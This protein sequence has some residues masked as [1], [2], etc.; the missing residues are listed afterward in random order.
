MQQNFEQFV[1]KQKNVELKYVGNFLAK[2]VLVESENKFSLDE[3]CRTS[4]A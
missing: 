4:T 2:T 1:G 3:L